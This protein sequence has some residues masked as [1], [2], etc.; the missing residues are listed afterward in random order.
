M[1][2]ASLENETV[3]S[4]IGDRNEENS[5][6]HSSWKCFGKRVPKSEIVYACQVAI[7]YMVIIVCIVN[8]TIHNGESCLWTAL[9]SSSLGYMLP[10]P[11]L[12][13]QKVG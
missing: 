2:N 9:L 10:A 3:L 12:K 7:L 4:F 6:S 11:S 13:S 8:L 5:S 1:A